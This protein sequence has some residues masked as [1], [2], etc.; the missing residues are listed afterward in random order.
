MKKGV[1]TSLAICASLVV[2][3]WV[4]FELRA[5]PKSDKISDPPVPP[6]NKNWGRAFQSA[7][8]DSR[9]SK[10]KFILRLSNGFFIGFDAWEL[11]RRQNVLRFSNCSIIGRKGVGK[12][13]RQTVTI[14]SEY[15]I[16]STTGRLEDFRLSGSR[17]GESIRSIRFDDGSRF[18]FPKGDEPVASHTRNSDN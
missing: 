3:I 6:S 12:K 14:C 5:E 1:L 7:F 18:V 11:D 4:S 16:V 8:G 2:L 9:Y 10:P 17:V 15:G 13:T